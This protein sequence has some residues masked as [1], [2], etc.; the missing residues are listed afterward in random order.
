M[1]GVTFVTPFTEKINV[2]AVLGYWENG[3]KKKKGAK[4]LNIRFLIASI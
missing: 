2:K 1:V 4:I 3:K